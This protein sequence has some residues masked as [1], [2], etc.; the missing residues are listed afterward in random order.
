MEFAVIAGLFGLLLGSFLN[1]AAYR[2]PQMNASGIVR[3]GKPWHFLALPLS[4]CP[5]CQTPIPPR[6]NIPVLSFLWLRGRAHCCR[7]PISRCYPLVEAAGAF[8]CAASA[9]RF[10][11]NLD[12]VFAAVFLS[13]LL[14]ASVIDMRKY[15]LLDTLTLPL[16]WFGLLVNLDSRFALLPDA[17][18]GA[19]GG[20][21]AM[22][23]LAAAGAAVFRQTAI[24]GGDIKLAAALGAWLGWQPLPFLI[25]LACLTGLIYALVFQVI[26]RFRK[27][28]EKRRN[29]SRVFGGRFCF[30]PALSLAGAVMLFYGDSI[31][32]SYWLFV[33]GGR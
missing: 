15:Y 32:A 2:L 16:L 20:F 13:A 18:L 17:V 1:V 31:I 7:K 14:V 12:F 33:S 6:Y 26:R 4:Y 8:I 24:G 5:H 21:L 27:T 28:P 30:G 29:F 19:A 3:R 25:F 10:G 23:I 11:K 9:V 22:R